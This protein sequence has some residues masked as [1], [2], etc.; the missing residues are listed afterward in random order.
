MGIVA[1]VIPTTNP[2]ST[3]AFKALCCLKTRNAIVVAPHPR[4]KRS[5]FEALRIIYE[6]AVA[7]GAPREIMACVQEPSI[8]LTN[9][10]MSHTQ[11]SLVLATGGPA[12]VKAAYASGHPAVGV[13]PGNVPV[14]VDE[15]A[16]LKEVASNVVSSKNFD[17][18]VICSSEQVVIAMDIV[19]EDLK[20]EFIAEGA[21]FCDNDQKQ[22]LGSLMFKEGGALN[23]AV[24]GMAP[25]K[26]AEMAGITVP[27]DVS[28]L[29]CEFDSIAESVFA[30]EKLSPV[31]GFTKGSSVND[32]FDMAVSVLKLGGEGHTACF[33]TNKFTQEARVRKFADRVIVTRCLINQPTAPGGIGGVY[34]FGMAPSMT[35]GCGSFGGNYVSDNVGPMHL[36]NYKRV[37]RMATD[38]DVVLNN[39]DCLVPPHIATRCAVE[40]LLTAILLSASDA[41]YIQTHALKSVYDKA[42]RFLRSE[43]MFGSLQD[44]REG[45][46]YCVNKNLYEECYRVLDVASISK[47]YNIPVGN[48]FPIVFCAS[49]ERLKSLDFSNCTHLQDGMN[50]YA[51]AVELISG[52]QVEKSMFTKFTDSTYNRILRAGSVYEDLKSI[53]K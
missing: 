22:K 43:G 9:S 53:N 46:L 48:L 50:S 35:L 32:L 19:Y 40:L 18:G 27:D 16:N 47:E 17:N 26:I 41:L 21:H 11:T 6:G 28:L 8:V 15:F 39:V 34:N 13:G 25:K 23:P 1:A 7:Y 20:K 31:L 12:M 24:V 5:T 33:Y 30:R 37:S 49:G 38:H 52:L 4:A 51:K 14:V 10:L 29:V 42:L 36:L 44:L 2:T 3:V 45:I